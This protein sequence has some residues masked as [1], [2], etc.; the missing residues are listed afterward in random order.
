MQISQV[1][2]YVP[3]LS[4]CG[5]PKRQVDEVQTLFD[6]IELPEE[7]GSLY[8]YGSAGVGKTLLS[9][10][11][12]LNA[13]SK[14]RHTKYLVHKLDILSTQY[15]SSYVMELKHLFIRVPD[16]LSRIR[17]TF[18]HKDPNDYMQETERSIIERYSTV[19]FLVLDDFGAEKITDWSF[20]VL[21]LIIDNRYNNYKRTIITSNYP[22]NQL[23]R[24]L[25]DDRIPS[26]IRT[27]CNLV[28]VQGADRRISKKGK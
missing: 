26:R 9:V 28:K 27:M 5:V 7:E 4:Y 11:L 19:D 2:D 3:L 1:Q 13:L 12:L 18:D 22:L 20:S 10:K 17:K 25:K 14:D 21:Y 6:E 23:A 8:L 15:D 16:L 24:K